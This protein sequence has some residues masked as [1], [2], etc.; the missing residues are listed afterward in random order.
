MTRRRFPGEEFRPYVPAD[1]RLSEFTAVSVTVGCVLAVVFGAANAYAG[2]K[3]G[4]TVSASIPAAVISM[5]ILRGLLRR[6]TIL[7]NNIVQTIGSSGEAL[8]A[9]VIFTL[10]A[11]FMWGTPPSTG[12][13]FLLAC[14]GGVLGILLMIPIRR[15]LVVEEHGILPFPEG[16]ACAKILEAGAGGG[17]HAKVVFI[18]VGAA[19]VYK[20]LQLPFRLWHEQVT[21][22]PALLPGGSLGF[23]L[24]PMLLGVG[25]LIGARTAMVMLSGAVLGYLVLNPLIVFTAQAANAPFAA[26][27]PSL[28]RLLRQDYT[29][30]IGIGA[31]ILGGIMSLVS[32]LPTLLRSFSLIGVQLGRARHGTGKPPARTQ[33]DLPMG[34][35]G[36]GILGAAI[37]IPVVVGGGVGVVG[38]LMAVLCAVLF[39]TVASRLVG[40]IG[41]SANP[42]SGMTIASLLLICVVL[43]GTGLEGRSGMAAAMSLGAI[44][45]LAICMAGDCAQDLKTGFLVGATPRLQQIAELIGVIV[46]ALFMG[47]LLALLDDRFGFGPGSALEA[48]QATAM[49]TL[50]EGVMTGTI[51]WSLIGLGAL[52]GLVAE[53]LR[54]AALPFAIGIY[55][56]PALTYPIMLGGFINWWLGR[57]GGGETG[58]LYA[59]GLVAGDAL[60]GIGWAVALGVPGLHQ[61]HERLI[62][63][64]WLGSAAEPGALLI[65]G[66]LA[67]T[68]WW[69]AGRPRAGAPL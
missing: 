57:R 20:L 40:L 14:L 2:L 15:S 69:A 50:V 38:T 36:L 60:V 46:P 21:V 52:L 18:G 1:Q 41:S 35:V 12:R 53:L 27:G 42:V 44:V 51:P 22:F 68:L 17:A 45:C 25:F 30:Y 9:G 16:T 10:P 23:E 48:P 32:A 7:E 62:E 66:A 19:A 4:M 24:T 3:I 64:G 5:A 11:F 56:P 28:V 63:G 61:W 67:G 33:R 47:S 55:L 8:A 34:A 54:A 59:S 49:K 37:V 39:V 65:F 26:Q 6:G 29:R 13:V 43:L 31:V 58:V